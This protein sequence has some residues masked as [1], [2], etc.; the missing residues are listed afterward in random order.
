MARYSVRGTS[1]WLT[2]HSRWRQAQPG[3]EGKHWNHLFHHIMY[4]DM[5]SLS[6]FWCHNKVTNETCWSNT[7]LVCMRP[8][9]MAHWQLQ[10]ICQLQS[11]FQLRNCKNLQQ[12]LAQFKHIRLVQINM[13]HRDH[14][15]S[16]I[17]RVINLISLLLNLRAHVRAYFVT[18]LLCCYKVQ[19][20]LKILPTMRV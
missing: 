20:P 9:N 8:I 6:Q 18:L 1:E 15:P 10:F 12:L 11:L 3:A 16:G 13:Y 5:I 4:V 7:A 2:R 19:T 14:T 17:L